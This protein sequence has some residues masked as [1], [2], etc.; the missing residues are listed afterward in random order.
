MGSVTAAA[1]LTTSALAL[2]RLDQQGSVRG[3]VFRKLVDRLFWWQRGHCAL[4]YEAERKR[5][6]FPPILR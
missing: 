1:R 4:A 6:Q 3:R 2:W 5:Y